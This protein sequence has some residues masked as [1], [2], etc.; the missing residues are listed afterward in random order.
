MGG[1]PRGQRGVRSVSPPPRAL[2][3]ALDAAEWTFPACGA[4]SAAG[5]DFPLAAMGALEDAF[6]AFPPHSPAAALSS[7]PSS[8]SPPS[9]SPD[10]VAAVPDAAGGR[11]AP[12][13]RSARRAVRLRAVPS[14]SGAEDHR[15]APF[16]RSLTLRERVMLEAAGFPLPEGAITRRE[17]RELRKQLR[18]S[19]TRPQP[20]RAAARRSSTSRASRK[21][22][23]RRRRRTGC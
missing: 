6:G 18:N 1:G 5:A 3:D 4:H 23:T 12:R 15:Y 19:R 2:L 14:R 8:P 9:D 11:G 13:R 20:R 21:G 17:E 22:C 10:T 7:T 16:V